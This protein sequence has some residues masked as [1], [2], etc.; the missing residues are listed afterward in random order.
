MKKKIKKKTK[1]YLIGYQ[2]NPQ[3][4]KTPI[5]STVK[6]TDLPMTS[7]PPININPAFRKKV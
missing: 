2:V 6:P 1:Q 7:A 4:V 5:F 3:G